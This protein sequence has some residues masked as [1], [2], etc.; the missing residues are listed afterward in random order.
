VRKPHLQNSLY[1]NRQSHSRDLLDIAPK[2]PRVRK[3]GV[4][5]KR[6]DPSPRPEAGARLIESEVSI[7]TNA[8]EEEF[9]TPDFLDLLLEVM[10]LGFQIRRIAIQDMNIGRVD[11]YVRE[12]MVEHEA[13]VAT[14]VFAGNPDIFV[15]HDCG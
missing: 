4:V 14:R 10:A 5:G 11:V 15:L 8:A 9:D 13:V 7:G 6:L 1:P 3:N 2:E 12:E